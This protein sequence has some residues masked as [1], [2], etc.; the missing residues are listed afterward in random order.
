M[1]TKRRILWASYIMPGIIAVLRVG[2]TVWMLVSNP[3]EL[4]LPYIQ[5]IPMCLMLWSCFAHFKLYSDSVPV[6]S[7]IAPD[8]VHFILILVFKREV[9]ILP[10]LPLVIPDVLY[11]V[12]K[13]VKANFFPFY[14]EGDSD[15]EDLDMDDIVDDAG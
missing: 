13:G 8:M 15:D 11:L 14:F 6:I 7:L 2:F 9:M 10:L 5:I 12:A 3:M 1:F 4:K